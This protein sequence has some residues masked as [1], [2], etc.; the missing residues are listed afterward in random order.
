[1]RERRVSYLIGMGIGA[2]LALVGGG[3]LL[4]RPAGATTGDSGWT[5]VSSPNPGSS[6]DYLTGVS[7]PNLSHCWAVGSQANGGS[8]YQTLVPQGLILGMQNDNWSIPDLSQAGVSTPTGTGNQLSGVTCLSA[9]DCWAVGTYILPNSGASM[10]LI[11]SWGGT[12]STLFA[13]TPNQD[14]HFNY[15]NSIS[16][17]DGADC[18]AVGAYGNEDPT[19]VLMYGGG[20]SPTPTPTPTST[21]P[22]RPATP[23]PTGAPLPSTGGGSV[24][25]RTPAGAELGPVTLTAGLAVLLLTGAAAVGRRMLRSH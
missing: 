6:D 3:T 8:P 20:A 2:V 9:T 4:A 14:E 18:A 22:N 10:T 23:T 25:P 19:L 12:A 17:G 11:D 1:M 5:L 13:G 7:C 15:L 21:P 16:C 24:P